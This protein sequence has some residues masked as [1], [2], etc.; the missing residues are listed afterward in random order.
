MPEL[1]KEK[2]FINTSY[3]AYQRFDPL[4]GFAKGM[5]IWNHSK[6]PWDDSAPSANKIINSLNFF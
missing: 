4:H 6:S 1:L 5:D 3:V 2:N